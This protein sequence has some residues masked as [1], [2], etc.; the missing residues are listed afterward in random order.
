M[1][2][3]SNHESSDKGIHLGS[4]LETYGFKQLKRKQSSNPILA[5]VFP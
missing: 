4:S 2:C 1:F 5:Y 3:N